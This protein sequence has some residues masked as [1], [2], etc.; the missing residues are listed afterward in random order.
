MVKKNLEFDLQKFAV[1]SEVPGS[2]I[3]ILITAKD[4]ATSNRNGI[5]SQADKAKLDSIYP[6]WVYGFKIKKNESDP[7]ARVEYTDDCADFEPLRV[8]LSTGDVDWGSWENSP[9][10]NAFRP[11]A[12]KFD[13]TVDYE[14]DHNDH[15][16]KLDGTASDVSDINYEGNF[17]VGVKKL[18]FWCYDDFDYHYCKVSNYPQN[19]QY[20]CYAHI[21]N[22]GEEVDEIYL[23]MF[24]GTKDSS[25]RLR[26]V[27]GKVPC[28][29][30]GGAANEIA[31]AKANGSGWYIDDFIN[32]KM[33]ENLT[34]LLTKS[35]H[36]QDTIGVGFTCGSWNNKW[37]G[38][39]TGTMM[40]KG[41]FYGTSNNTVSTMTGVKLFYLENY[42]GSRWDRIAGCINNKGRYLIKPSRPYNDETTVGL[43]YIDTG[44]V[45]PTASG[46]YQSSHIMTSIGLLP[47]ICSGSET[48]Y[49]PDGMWS[50]NSQVDYGLRGGYWGN[51]SICGVSYLLVNCVF[52]YSDADDGASPCYK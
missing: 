3:N 29:T 41:M 14:L 24:E 44:I 31:W 6:H 8:D 45:V 16:K 2:G 43:N 4:L 13:G 27:A 30:T 32:T 7:E 28:Y 26:S 35:C 52:S 11:V 42:Y 36:S 48:T 5:M 34:I 50:N 39:S 49:I 37:E 51:G 21:N 40:D 19:A 25:N 9:V 23:P 18:Y 12:L 15:T 1:I 17:M 47:I 10:V 46:S 33:I 38:Q 22:D 20:Q